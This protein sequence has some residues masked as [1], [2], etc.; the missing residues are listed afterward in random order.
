MSSS[1]PVFIVPA[2]VFDRLDPIEKIVIQRQAE[3]GEVK[4]L[5]D[6]VKVPS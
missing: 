6:A 3:R 2:E 5:K 1:A 4:I